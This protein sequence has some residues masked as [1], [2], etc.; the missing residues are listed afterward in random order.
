MPKF[1]R[2]AILRYNLACYACQLGRLEEAKIWL[3]EAFGLDE[4]QELKLLALE[5]PDLKPLWQVLRE[6]L[7]S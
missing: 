7:T 3:R 2:N 5:D 6:G 1:P 4:K